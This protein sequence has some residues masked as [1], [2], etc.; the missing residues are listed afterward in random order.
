M[1]IK[2]NTWRA[3]DTSTSRSNYILQSGPEKCNVKTHG[4]LI[5]YIMCLRRVWTSKQRGAASHSP[6]IH[7]PHQ[8]QQSLLE[9]TSFR[10]SA[11]RIDRSD[12]WAIKSDGVKVC[13]RVTDTSYQMKNFPSAKRAAPG[14]G[15]SF[16][17]A[18]ELHI[19][20]KLEHK[21]FL[22]NVIP[23]NK[24]AVGSVSLRGS[25]RQWLSSNSTLC[26]RI[27]SFLTANIS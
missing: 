27:C 19:K 8:S 22:E 11:P 9:M 6:Q 12:T 18:E 1:K 3:A 25:G 26:D 15:G 5:F 2:C 17:G 24:K 13:R 10:A 4:W 7:H 23:L 21:Y 16:D 20:H 14:S